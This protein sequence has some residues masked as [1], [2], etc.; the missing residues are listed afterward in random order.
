MTRSI[1]L[2]F[3]LCVILPLFLF[4]SLLGTVSGNEFIFGKGYPDIQIIGD[5]ETG[6]GVASVA[7]GDING[8]GVEDLIVAG[9]LL[10]VVSVIFGKKTFPAVVKF[11]EHVKPDIHFTALPWTEPTYPPLRVADL[12][13]DGIDDLF[14]P[15]GEGLHVYWGRLKWPSHINVEKTTPDFQIVTTEHLDIETERP[16]SLVTTGDVNGDGMVDIL[17]THTV[18][19]PPPTAKSWDVYQQK[20]GRLFWGRK[21]WP[22]MIDLRKQEADVVIWAKQPSS[23]GGQIRQ[24]ALADLNGDG[25][26]DIVVGGWH[27]LTGAFS[28]KRE[29]P[30]HTGWIIPGRT[31]FS[32]KV[33]L[34]DTVSDSPSIPSTASNASLPL[35]MDPWVLGKVFGAGLAIDDVTGD[36]IK[37]LVLPLFKKRV[38]NSNLM[39]QRVCLLAGRKDFFAKGEE[40]ILRLCQLIFGS[41]GFEQAYA[42]PTRPPVLGDFNGDGCDDIF[43]LVGAPDN[44][45]KGLFGQSFSSPTIDVLLHE[46]VNFR[47][48]EFKDRISPFA[49]F[50]SMGDINGDGKDDLLIVEP[51]GGGKT[52]KE[53]GPGSLHIVLGRDITV[54]SEKKVKPDQ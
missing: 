11:S 52:R 18:G 33:V 23:D 40:N 17:F 39:P 44:T 49:T 14:F 26:D 32:S 45:I 47:I 42:F 3:H 36:G 53:Q 35:R 9:Q 27:Y 38:Q 24:V 29:G 12:N 13:G 21:H 22:T 15:H 46:T 1:R 10:H 51:L 19:L 50:M 34:H 7:T 30:W 28:D 2:V 37:D 16:Y 25:Y 54:E 6:I 4:V 20:V 5:F 43:L 41:P 48:P 31:K 8:D